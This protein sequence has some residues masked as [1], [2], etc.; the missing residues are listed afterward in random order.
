MNIPKPLSYTWT[1]NEGFKIT[2]ANWSKC[3]K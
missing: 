2:A 3:G 1:G